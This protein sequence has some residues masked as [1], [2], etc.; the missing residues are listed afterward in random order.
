ME[1]DGR[2]DG[3]TAGS[4]H[5]GGGTELRFESRAAYIP[6]GRKGPEVF[7]PCSLVWVRRVG[8]WPRDTLLQG[9]ERG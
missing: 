1:E 6:Q 9:V 7:A 4:G 3:T 8:D 2:L 5:R